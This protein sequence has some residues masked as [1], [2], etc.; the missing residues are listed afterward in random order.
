MSDSIEGIKLVRLAGKQIENLS[1]QVY[2]NFNIKF[3]GKISL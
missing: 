1:P 2:K 3:F